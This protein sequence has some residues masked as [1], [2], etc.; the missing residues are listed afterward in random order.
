MVK[1][2]DD[3]RSQQIFTAENPAKQRDN[4]VKREDDFGHSKFLPL[5]I[6][7]SEEMTVSQYFFY[8]QIF[9]QARG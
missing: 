3:F 6:Q 4:M 1:R 7:P 8:R 2:E 5:K 9:R